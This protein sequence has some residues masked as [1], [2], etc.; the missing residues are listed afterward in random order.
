LRDKFFDKKTLLNK[1]EQELI[2]NSDFK[3]KFKIVK[4][5]VKACFY[6]VF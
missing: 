6:L 1:V 5:Y 2:C 3:I 4:D